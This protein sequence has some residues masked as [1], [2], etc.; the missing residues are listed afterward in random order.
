MTSLT[1]SYKVVNKFLINGHSD[2]FSFI[3]ICL[4]TLLCLQLQ[5]CNLQASVIYLFLQV[6]EEAGIGLKSPLRSWIYSS[7][8][9]FTKIQYTFC[10]KS[11][12]NL[13]IIN[14]FFDGLQIINLIMQSK[15][16]FEPLYKIKIKFIKE[17]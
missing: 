1:F 4:L 5:R 16:K 15:C 2:D 13:Q 9:L 3:N 7:F 12:N 10:F 6:R 14:F 8:N 17:K 11:L